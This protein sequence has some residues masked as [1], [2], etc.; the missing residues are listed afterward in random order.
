M[1]EGKKR[2]EKTFKFAEENRK[3]YGKKTTDAQSSFLSKLYN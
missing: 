2:E 3:N 1:K